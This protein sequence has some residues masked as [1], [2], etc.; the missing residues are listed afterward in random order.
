M[1]EMTL[2][3]TMAAASLAASLLLL[4]A[5]CLPADAAPLKATHP[6]RIT[7]AE[8]KTLLAGGEQVLLVDTRTRGQWQLSGHKAEGAI[9]LES[10]RDIHDLV[11]KYPP[12][13]P[14]VIYCT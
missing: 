8:V 11:K 2:K 1:P 7:V 10:T 3:T 4:A 13:T 14:I 5:W 6:P 12:D 9:R